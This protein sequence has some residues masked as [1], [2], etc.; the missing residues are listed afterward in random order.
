LGL[1]D[2][3]PGPGVKK[4]PDPVSGSATL[5]S[6]QLTVPYSSSIINNLST[7]DF[8][9]KLKQHTTEVGTVMPKNA[10]PGPVSCLWRIYIQLWMPPVTLSH[11][12]S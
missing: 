6:N 8:G 11:E 10:Y 2:P 9:D 5:V 12:F 7:G 1:R 4:A 3:N